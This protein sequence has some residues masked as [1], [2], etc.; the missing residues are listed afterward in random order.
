M[1]RT[2]GGPRLDDLESHDSLL[3]K[4]ESENPTPPS[5]ADAIE[6]L[7]QMQSARRRAGAYALPTAY[8][9]AV[10]GVFGALLAAQGLPLGWRLAVEIAV[11]AAA[12]AMM[13]WSRRVTGRFVNG[14]RKGPTRWIA[15]T[16]T[17]AFVGLALA[18][19]EV[20]AT[21]EVRVAPLLA[22]VAMF[23][24]AAMA[25]WLWVQ[26]YRAELQR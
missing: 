20:D 22:G 16:L 25:D 12:L 3:S 8:H 13:A 2:A 21:H 7:R 17:V 26:F 6:A 11:V 5:R 4:L 18:T 10:G 14:W 23:V 9:L 24:I 15:V 19:L 1:G